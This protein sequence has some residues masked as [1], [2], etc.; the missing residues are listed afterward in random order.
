M[1]EP[2]YDD[3][4]GVNAY[5]NTCL[6]HYFNNGPAYPQGGQQSIKGVVN[7][8]NSII[9]AKQ[10]Q[11]QALNWESVFPI[12][13]VA[14]TTNNYKLDT[15]KLQDLLGKAILSDQVLTSLKTYT[16]AWQ[17]LYNTTKTVFANGIQGQQQSQ[18]GQQQ[19]DTTKYTETYIKLLAIYH[20]LKS[21][22]V[23]CIYVKMK[24]SVTTQDITTNLDAI[25]K[26]LPK[27]TRDNTSKQKTPQDQL[28]EV[29]KYI[30][31]LHDLLGISVDTLA[32]FS[33]NS[34]SVIDSQPN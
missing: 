28:Q 23:I 33:T 24:V 27:K 29:K 13:S 31:S 12:S 5:Y 3:K 16:T 20:F 17:T 2:V 7:V 25:M 9:P 8:L 11:Q 1:A 30:E 15:G 18:Q 10:G 6:E 4:E 21:M 32:N 14:N 34:L 22:I 19:K 26:M